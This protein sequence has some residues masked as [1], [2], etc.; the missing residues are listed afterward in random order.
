MSRPNPLAT[1]A[2]THSS[3]KEGSALRIHAQ[4]GRGVSAVVYRGAYEAGFG[5]K[6]EVAVKVFNVLA[7]EDHEAVLSTL[8]IA[9][10]RSACVR[11]PNVVRVEDFGLLEPTE[12]YFVLELVEGCSLAGLVAHLAQKGERLPLDLALF[13]GLEVAEGLDG[14]RVA[15]SPDATPLGVVHGSLAASD[16]LLS[17]H[18]EV[19]VGDFGLAAASRA[20]SGLRSSGCVSQRLR[21]LAPEV[22]CGDPSDARS[23]VFSL[24]VL[25]R[26]MLVGPRFPPSASNSEVLA[27]ARDGVVHQS[28]F[29]P[30]PPPLLRAVLTRALE[31][32]PRR[33]YPHAG[34]L[35]AE[36]RRAAFS[37]GVGDGRAFLRA[38]L[39]R[40]FGE[41][42]SVED[43]DTQVDGMRPRHPSGVIDRFARLRG[44]ASTERSIEDPRAE[45]AES[46]TQ[47]VAGASATSAKEG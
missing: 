1:P 15:R 31:R 45:P 39:A 21:T 30:Q 18:G 26:E 23:H 20:A 24:G 11:H 22:V 47:L 4:L 13:I 10:R 28:M 46:M 37:L 9:A 35:A 42:E 6:R 43:D 17:R 33:R 19:K 41:Q 34:A 27:W 44:D 12:P 3:S 25:L 36:L 32:E 7:S 14:A 29:E 40:A 2:P 8:A 16:V 5:M 38:A